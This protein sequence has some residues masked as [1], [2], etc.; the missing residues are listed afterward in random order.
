M[1]GQEKMEVDEKRSDEYERERTSALSTTT[2][3]LCMLSGYYASQLAPSPFLSSFISTGLDYTVF[4]G[5]TPT[6]LQTV[7]RT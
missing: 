7:L 1:R 3:A 5:R 4:L 2:T 6:Q